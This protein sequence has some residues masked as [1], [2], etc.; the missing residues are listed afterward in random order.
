MITKSASISLASS[1]EKLSS[2]SKGFGQ[3]GI[4]GRGL[5]DFVK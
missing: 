2:H 5:S 1:N 4:G 3:E